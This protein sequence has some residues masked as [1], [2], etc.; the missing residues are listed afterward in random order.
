MIKEAITLHAAGM[1][2]TLF[3]CLSAP[4]RTHRKNYSPPPGFFFGTWTIHKFEEVGGHAFEKPEKAQKEIG[5]K[6]RFEKTTY[7]SD[8]GF[9]FF[10]PKPC[11]KVRYLRTI[12]RFRRE[13]DPY[14]KG[15]LLFYGVSGAKP[16]RTDS[17]MVKCLGRMGE[18]AFELTKDNE[19]AIYYDGFFFYLKK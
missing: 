12:E 15:T 10:E 11:A 19:L 13:Y 14:E 3:L 17:V 2:I 4:A 8:Q 6:I 7:S 18:A 16:N 9:L 5:K 1:V